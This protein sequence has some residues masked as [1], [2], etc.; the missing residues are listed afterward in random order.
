MEGLDPGTQYTFE[1]RAVNGIGGGDET[2]SMPRT[3]P[4]PTWSFTLRDSSNN[5]V[6]ELTEGGDAATATVSITNNVRFSTDQTVTLKWGTVDLTVG[7]VV[8]AGGA[9]AITISA[10][11]A[12]G[13]LEISSP[14]HA[15]VVYDHPDTNSLS[16]TLGDTELGSIDLTRL[17][18]EDPPVAS[19]TQ[20]PTT[21]NEGDDINIKVTLSVGSSRGGAVRLTVTAPSGT[22]SGTLPDRAVFAGAE[23]EHTVTLNTVE[24]TAI[25]D[26]ARDVVLTL[27]PSPNGEFDIPYTLGTTHS[28]T[29]TV[30]DNDTPPLAPENLRAQAGNTEATLRWDAPLPST[31]DH[32]QPVLHYEYRV[33]VGTGSFSAWA[34]IPGGD[35]STRS[36]T[37]TGLTNG[38][39]YTYEVAAVNVAGR[40]TEAQKSVTPLVGVAVS[41]GAATLSVDEGQNA[42]VTVTLATAPAASVTVPLTATRGTGLDSTEYSGVPA[43]VTFNAGETSKSFTVTTVDDT[44]DEPHRVLTLGLG[45]LPEGYVP[46]TH[47]EFVL[48]L[49]DDDHPI[50]SA[51]FGDAADSA[52]EGASVEVTVRLSQAPGR[53]VV[54][55]LTA[56]RGANLGAD[57]HEAVPVQRDLRGR[58][59]REA[60]HAELRGRRRRGGQRDADACV[61]DASGPCERGGREP[62]ARADGDGRR[63]PA[64][65][66]GCVGADGERVRGAVV[67]GGC[68]RQ[69]GAALRGA[70]AGDRRRRR[71]TPGGRWGWRRATR[72]RG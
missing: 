69:P 56:T 6:T 58:R 12:S 3:T 62:A 59:D 41:F 68:Q 32:G 71:S 51:T 52:P 7:S 66:A 48:T 21:V 20:A 27:D 14:Q 15:A 72:W 60:L 34:M 49:L 24:N 54:V 38:T 2:A 37:F 46:G 63:R 33:K 16:A 50:V 53:E 31:P 11:Q 57:E 67:A 42:E 70:L 39:E 40:G 26:G 25:N 36:R 17:D 4:T 19:I 45:E 9:T 55:P 44:D 65:G 1:V 22:L 10:E 61:R 64:G 8:G 35:A 5:N 13:S 23:T 30:R 28:V 29:V 18:D 43:S 47:H